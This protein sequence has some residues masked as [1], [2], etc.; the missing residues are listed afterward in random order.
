MKKRTGTRSGLWVILSVVVLFPVAFAQQPSEIP[1]LQANVIGP[2]LV[3]WS[4]LQKPQPM[5]Q[6]LPPPER[7]D[8]SQ[9]DQ[10]QVDRSQDQ[11]TQP[12]DQVQPSIQAFV[13]T[14]VKDGSRYVF[15]VSEGTVYQLDDQEKAKAYEGKKVRISGSLDTKS[16]LLHITSIESIS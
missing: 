16:T 12:L 4:E 13:G 11:T 8:Q 5:P 1:N 2:Q 7:A 3:A 6:P 15:K 14:I 10:S 9:A